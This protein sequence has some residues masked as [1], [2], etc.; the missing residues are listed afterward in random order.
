MA[1]WQGPLNDPP[2]IFL[3]LNVFEL[4]DELDCLFL[5]GP[6]IC[7]WPVLRRLLVIHRGDGPP[8]A[9]VITSDVDF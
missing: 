6:L 2:E 7:I 1:S 4:S 5:G 9:L 3:I 8:T